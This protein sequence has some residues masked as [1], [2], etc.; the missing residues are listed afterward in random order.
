MGAEYSTERTSKWTAEVTDVQISTPKKDPSNERTRRVA[1][2]ELVDNA[3]DAVACVRVTLLNQKRHSPKEPWQDPEFFSAVKLKAG[4]QI[5]FSLSASQARRLYDA[6]RDMYKLGSNGLPEG[7]QKLR[8]IDADDS[9]VVAGKEKEL[10]SRLIESEGNKFFDAVSE[11]EPDL[12]ENAALA[13]AYRRRQNAVA[14]FEAELQ[15]QRWSEQKWDRFFRE[16]TWI[17]GHGLA[18]QFLN[19]VESQPNY[20]GTGLSGTGGQRGDYLMSTEAKAKFTVLVE[21]KK[22]EGLLV[23]GERYRNKVHVL[24]DDLTGGVSQLQSNCRTWALEGAKQ[25]D[26]FERLAEED[27]HTYEPK[28]I[29]IVGTTA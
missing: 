19:T 8:V 4:E 17:F 15:K 22:P 6:L 11:L 5:R 9:Y 10:I 1:R 29:L 26:N 7:S 23:T 28:G 13:R 24:G 3:K 14:E 16:N 25:E 20:G 18:Y 21:I 12:F 2:M 27:V